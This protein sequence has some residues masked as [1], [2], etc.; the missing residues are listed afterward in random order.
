MDYYAKQILVIS[1]DE[2]GDII[3]DNEGGRPITN[4]EALRRQGRIVDAGRHAGAA[5]VDPVACERTP[6]APPPEPPKQ[7]TYV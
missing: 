1:F 6:A 7:L 2:S 3:L 4:S 5:D